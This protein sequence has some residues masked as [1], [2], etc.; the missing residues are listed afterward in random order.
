MVHSPL[1][2]DADMVEFVTQAAELPHASYTQA[3]SVAGINRMLNRVGGSSNS[4]SHAAGERRAE[5]DGDACR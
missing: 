5:Q 3:L 4:L 1:Q 2:T